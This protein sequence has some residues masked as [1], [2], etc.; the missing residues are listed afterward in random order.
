MMRR[1]A[2]EHRGLIRAG[3]D[4][5]GTPSRKVIVG[6]AILGLCATV[7]YVVLFST[8][9]PERA[10][11]TVT[12]GVLCAAA[13]GVAMVMALRG[14]VVPAGVTIVTTALLSLLPYAATYPTSS[15]VQILC[16][17]VGFMVLAV[18]P[19]RLVKTRLVY[20][21]TVIAVILG[22]EWWS[23]PGADIP[24]NDPHFALLATTSRLGGIAVVLTSTVLILLRTARAEGELVRLARDGE[25][26]ANTDSLTGIPNR[27]PVMRELDALDADARQY[28][29][30]ALVDLDHFKTIND[31][32]GHDVGD[33]V[34]SAV[35]E[36]L[37]AEL[38]ESCMVARWGGDEFLVLSS[39]KAT[40]VVS[41][42]E[43]LCLD[44]ARTPLET[45]AGTF[46]LTLSGG[47]ARREQAE[48]ARRVLARADG[49]LYQAKSSGRRRVRV[50]ATPN[51]ASR[52]GF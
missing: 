5:R 36:R 37:T 20:C 4:R 32:H 6:L 9:I 18:I 41:T 17:A 16:L 12:L 31:R 50:A 19:E 48:P 8:W 51:P 47:V 22:C 39:D 25:R 30:V 23:P 46:A 49:A 15:G 40:D 34:I 52:S 38:G 45:P 7:F 26:R 3:Y 42:L 13:Y 21:G 43:R 14:L 35:A 11:L 44:F 29:C 10:P 28:A 27:R 2:R 1:G 33:A 24:L